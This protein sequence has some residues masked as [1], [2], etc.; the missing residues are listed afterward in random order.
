[1]PTT[2]TNYSGVL[3]PT[4]NKLIAPGSS[5]GTLVA[6]GSQP[7]LLRVYRRAARVQWL[8]ENPGVNI[9]PQATPISNPE[10]SGASTI[11]MPDFAT[12]GW[13]ASGITTNPQYVGYTFG[14]ATKV[15]AMR[16][17]NSYFDGT[18]WIWTN[19]HIQLLING[20][21]SDVG[22]AAITADGNGQWWWCYLGNQTVSGVRLYGDTPLGNNP[23]GGGGLIV[24]R[25]EIYG[26]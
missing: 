18:T 9:A 4:S 17:I 5:G 1:M 24:N 3:I 22:T 25:I 10:S 23:T 15:K 19:P 6:D 2:S 20:S 13:R 16:V 26:G 8:R 7:P 14:S 11:N 12:R 21:W